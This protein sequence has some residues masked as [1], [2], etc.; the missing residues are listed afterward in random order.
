MSYVTG[1]HLEDRVDINGANRASWAA[2][3]IPQL[4]RGA[5]WPATA[6]VGIPVPTTL[7]LRSDG[8]TDPLIRQVNGRLVG[9]HTS[10]QPGCP[11]QALN[12]VT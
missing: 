8:C 4:R 10:V 12:K 2:S 11:T 5:R 1:A 6:G 9:G 3:N 7:T